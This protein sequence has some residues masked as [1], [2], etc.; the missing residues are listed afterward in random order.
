MK[1]DVVGNSITIKRGSE[2]IITSIDDIAS[3]TYVIKNGNKYLVIALK[4]GP[5]SLVESKVGDIVLNGVAFT[6]FATLE[7]TLNSLMLLKT[8]FGS[9][10]TVADYHLQGTYATAGT[11]TVTVPNGLT[12]NNSTQIVYIRQTTA[13]LACNTYI[14][15]ASGYSFGYNAGTITIYKYGVAITTLL[16]TDK[17]E[18]G[19]NNTISLLSN[20][21]VKTLEVELT[22]PSD[23]NAYA[24]ND[25]INT[26]TSGSSLLQFTNAA[27][28][29]GTGVII[30]SARFQTNSILSSGFLGKRFRLH[31]YRDSGVTAINDNAAFEMLYE[32]STKR[33]GYI[34]FTFPSVVDGGATDSIAVQVDGINKIVQLV[35]TTIYGQ[36]QI[37]DAITAP[38][39][40]A[41]IK[42]HLHVIQTN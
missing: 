40:G 24:A 4:Y 5:K 29:T 35:G 1:I 42:I 20:D 8:S 21:A 9:P 3:F 27:K 41:K 13:A 19:I 16:N 14:N 36:L 32:N 31:L 23:T 11:V 33:I 17:Y 30:A 38:V 37:L 10:S 7:S 15:G 34:D 12:V 18:V 39:S 25:C 6:N 2:Q 22:R 28:A 26:A